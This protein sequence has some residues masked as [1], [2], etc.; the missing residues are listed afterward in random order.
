MDTALDMIFGSGEAGGKA[1]VGAWER[2]GLEDMIEGERKGS[3]VASSS[4]SSTPSTPTSSAGPK[5]E[6]H[7]PNVR[8]LKD[9]LRRRLEYSERTAGEGLVQVSQG[10]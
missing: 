10:S 7:T 9:R 4:S 8:G 1:L 3:A 2:K 6:G 5:N